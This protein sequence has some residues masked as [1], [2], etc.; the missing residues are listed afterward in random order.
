M[1]HWFKSDAAGAATKRSAAEEAADAVAIT[2][3]ATFML[4]T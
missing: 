4:Y 2:D 1:K 3:P